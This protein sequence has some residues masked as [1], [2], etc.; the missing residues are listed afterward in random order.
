MI[1]LTNPYLAAIIV[2][3]IGLVLIVAVDV[4][5]NGADFAYLWRTV[6]RDKISTA[7]SLLALYA[8]SYLICSG[9]MGLV[10]HFRGNA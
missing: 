5:N 8:M 1:L 4:F 7:A 2:A 3:L 9:A 6:K 10:A